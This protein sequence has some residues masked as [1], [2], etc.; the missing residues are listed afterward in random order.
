MMRVCTHVF[1]ETEKE[2]REGHK[3]FTIT[4]VR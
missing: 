4:E 1:T 2:E 3:M